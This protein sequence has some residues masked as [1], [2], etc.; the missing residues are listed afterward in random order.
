M[1]SDNYKPLAARYD[2]MSSDNP[3]RAEFFS[4]LF[5]KH[6][7]GSILDCACGTG[8]DLLLFSKLGLD[9]TGSD[10][11]ESMLEQARNKISESGLNIPVIHADFRQLE[12]CFD[13]QFDS[14][15]CLNNSIN[16]MHD[17]DEAVR[18]L[19]SMKSLLNNTGILVIDQGQTDFS[20]VNPPKYAPIINDR[21]LTRVFVMEY[22]SKIMTVHILDFIHTETETDFVKSTHEIKIRLIYDWTDIISRAG[23]TKFNFYGGWDFEQYDKNKS[24]RLIITA[25][26]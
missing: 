25:E 21:D 10:L 12:T 2:R 15:V 6:N 9:I 22:E 19:V 13:R 23:F 5:V 17:D 11:S 16:E 26:K 8:R 20:M 7:V 1:T 18:V 24:M 14:I 4:K 3:D